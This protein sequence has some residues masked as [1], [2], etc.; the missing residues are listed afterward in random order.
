MNSAGV[1]P[2]NCILHPVYDKVGSV[3]T[4]LCFPGLVRP[5]SDSQV[6]HAPAAAPPGTPAFTYVPAGPGGAGAAAPR[7]ASTGAPNGL[8]T[9]ANADIMRGASSAGLC[10]FQPDSKSNN[11]VWWPAYLCRDPGTYG[12]SKTCAICYAKDGT[13]RCVVQE[14]LAHRPSSAI[15]GD[16]SWW[17]ELQLTSA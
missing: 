4:S 8:D 15:A 2:C 14:P 1:H 17:R 6:L 16:W 12:C 11:V 13:E 3:L 9:A 10:C 7:G 5:L